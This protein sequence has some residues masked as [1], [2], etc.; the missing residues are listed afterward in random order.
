MLSLGPE[1]S[2]RFAEQ[3]STERH[4]LRIAVK[5]LRYIIEILE[6]SVRRDP[7]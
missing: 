1:N 7:S 2:K 5:K 3:T 6:S 4:R